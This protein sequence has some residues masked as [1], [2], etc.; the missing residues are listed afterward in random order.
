MLTELT[1]RVLEAWERGAG[2]DIDARTA[3]ALDVIAP[4]VAR[5]EACLYER[6]RDLVA[7]WR[8]LFGPSIDGVVRC[9]AC[10]ADFEM[11]LDLRLLDADVPPPEPVRVEAGECVA[12]VRPPQRADLHGLGNDL[13]GAGDRLFARCVVEASC[14]GEPIAAHQ[15]PPAVRAAAS[16]AIA[17][18]GM[19]GP[20]L[21]LVC[22]ECAHAWRAPLDVAR[23]LIGELDGWVAGLLADVHRLAAIYH[24]PERD[25]LALPARRRAYYLEAIG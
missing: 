14:A 3:I 19:E 8:R 5:E 13:A 9:P 17:Q 11:P 1:E 20:A 10:A 15:V 23:A 2:L 7:L 24:W 16:A 6:D 12:M 18:R 4:G 21:D 22:G 25:I